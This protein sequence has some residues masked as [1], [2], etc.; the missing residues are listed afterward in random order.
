LKLCGGAK[1]ERRNGIARIIFLLCF[2]ALACSIPALTQNFRGGPKELPAT[3]EITVTVPQERTPQPVES[4]AAVLEITQTPEITVEPSSSDV[5]DSQRIVWIENGDVYIWDASNGKQLIAA[6]LRAVQVRLSEDGKRAAFLSQVNDTTFELHAVNAD[7]SGM[8]TLLAA[9][10]LSQYK[11]DG[12]VGVSVNNFSWVPGADALVFSTIQITP[13][14]WAPDGNLVIISAPQTT[15]GYESRALSFLKPSGSTPTQKTLLPV[16]QGGYSL[17]S[18]SGKMLAVVKSDSVNLVNVDGSD[19]R[20]VLK[21]TPVLTYSE[22]AFYPEPCW[23]SDSSRLVV[24]IPPQDPLNAPGETLIWEIAVK[25][26]ALRQVASFSARSLNEQGVHISPDLTHVAYLKPV[27]NK[28]ELHIA[29]LDGSEDE[30]FTERVDNA[31]FSGWSTDSSQF[32]Y[33][34]GQP[35]QVKIGQIGRAP[36]DFNILDSAAGFRW[37]G[38]DSY[39]FL[40]GT[41]GEWQLNFVT[42]YH[43]TL[44]LGK[45]E[46]MSDFDFSIQP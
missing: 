22:T 23:S 41:P 2:S 28:V 17:A 7:G 35:G 1:M 29:R 10:D 18:P 32:A 20:T 45:P 38:A 3:P 36:A 46:N 34:T 6:G 16:G 11:K 39:L 42:Q 19:F 15:S 26:G 8:Q 37:V 33:W 30:A 44:P 25:D 12:S 27:D 4:P 9:A 40:N 13:E 21:F 24:A 43:Q 5:P 14:F 31:G